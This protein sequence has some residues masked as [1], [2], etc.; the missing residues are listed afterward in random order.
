[1]RDY[2]IKRLLLAI[3]T[4]LG[5]TIL[6]FL[7]LH[8][9]P[10][11][12]AQVMLYPR[13]T[14]EEIEALRVQLGL[15]Q[16]LITQ[17]IQWLGNAV[18]FDLGN[19][20]RTGEEVLN[21]IIRHFPATI[22]LA[23]AALLIAVVFGIPLGVIA[24]QKRNS[25]IDYITTTLSLA[26]VSIPV[27]WLGLMLIFVF[28]VILGWFPVSGRMTMGASMPIVTGMYTIDALIAGNYDAF[29]T[30]LKHLALPAISLATIPLA[31]IVRITRS[32][33]L[34]VLS[35]DYIRT[36]K[37]KGLPTRRIIYK[38]ALKNAL[39]PVVTVIGLQL[40]RMMGGAILTETVFSWPGIGMVVVSS[41]GV[42]DYPI[43]QGIILVIALGFVLINILV[44]VIY[45]YLDPRIRYN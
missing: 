43:V 15:H 31:I 39:I 20:V 26:G 1:M 45:A 5:V 6:V 37:A 34:D 29:L 40:G 13:G 18:Q 21:I 42:R 24:A 12:P 9:I 10:G 11:C 28:S 14:A 8:M 19:S 32:S 4:I 33:M 7:L 30:A 17:Y 25:I 44:D 35:Q 41:I 3:P 23:L 36:A 27:F 16:P 2:L 22:E 38:H